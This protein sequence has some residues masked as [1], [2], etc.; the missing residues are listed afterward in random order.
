MAD[1]RTSSG[2]AG[3]WPSPAA[4][5]IRRNRGWL[6]LGAAPWALGVCLITAAMISHN[7]KIRAGPAHALIFGL[8]GVSFAYKYNRTPTFEGGE[9]TAD[10]TGVRMNGQEL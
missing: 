10:R 8:I 1:S 2:P 4:S 3:A 5:L 6:A 9:F 7:Y